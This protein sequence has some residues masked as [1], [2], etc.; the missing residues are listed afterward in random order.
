M[1]QPDDVKTDHYAALGV[2]KEADLTKIRGAYRKLALS[3][4][5][6]KIKDESQRESAR[7]EWHRVQKAYEILSDDKDR[8]AYDNG[9]AKYLDKEARLAELKRELREHRRTD[10]SY[11]SPRGSGSASAREMRNG[12]IVEERVPMESYFDDAMRFTDEPNPMGRKN[13]DFG[14]RTKLRPTDDRRK[15][16]VPTSSQ[17]AAKDLRESTKASNADR[18]K[19]LA[20][21]R[22]HDASVKH[23]EKLDSYGPR[24]VESESDSEFSGPE[25]YLR[26]R[27]PS[28]SRRTRESTP[29]ESRSRPTKPAPRHRDYYDEEDT[30]S[31]GYDAWQSKFHGA[32]EHIQ[33]SKY[34]GGD[35]RPRTSRSPP[36]RRGYDGEPEMSGSRRAARSSQ[37][38]REPD[39]SSSRNN[40]YDKLDSRS[41]DYFKPPKMPSATT[42]P[43]VKSSI[44]PSLFTRATTAT[45][46]AFTRPKRESSSRNDSSLDQMLRNN[47]SGYSSSSTPEMPHSHSPKVTARYTIDPETITIEPSKYRMASPD[48]DRER[49]HS[50]RTMPPRA[51][52]FTEP[53]SIKIR[54]VKPSRTY[55]DVEYTRRGDVKYA[56]EIRPSD[57][58]YSP[59]RSQK[60]PPYYTERHPPPSRRQSTAA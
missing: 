34:E 37:S 19:K 55:T 59:S 4:H 35:S 43:N 31:D 24:I 38:T 54:S 51:N 3:L 25:I 45:A 30:Y 2:S 12:H 16:R 22:R 53:S 52:T 49:D 48:R 28:S 17:R 39:R 14:R 57:A 26:T 41:G 60:I 20:R 6:D 46:T 47:D 42:S 5:P 36:R 15:A 1:L 8:S 10:S 21:E 40:S 9:R 29:R 50:T 18:A 32:Q 56:K 11:A 7:E 33:R 58:T 27:E 44:R 13:D 23:E